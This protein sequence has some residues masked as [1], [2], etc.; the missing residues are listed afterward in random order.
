MCLGISVGS[1]VTT[2]RGIFNDVHTVLFFV[3]SDLENG[4]VM[5]ISD[6]SFRRFGLK[7]K[8]VR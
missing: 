6:L 4:L 7:R 2:L 1:W 3:G 8:S 5:R